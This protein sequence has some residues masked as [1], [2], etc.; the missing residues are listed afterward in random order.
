MKCGSGEHLIRECKFNPVTSDANND[1]PKS[2]DTEKKVAAVQQE[3][4]SIIHTSRIFNN[5]DNT[6][7]WGLD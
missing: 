5:E 7:D 4:V 2:K 6:L 3:E 1:Q